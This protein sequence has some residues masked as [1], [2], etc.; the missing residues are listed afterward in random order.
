MS[1]FPYPQIVS[2]R[3]LSSPDKALKGLLDE[4]L[5]NTASD[6]GGMLAVFETNGERNSLLAIRFRGELTDR[7]KEVIESFRVAASSR[8]METME[9]CDSLLAGTRSAYSSCLLAGSRIVG[10][11]HLADS[12][13]GYFDGSLNGGASKLKDQMTAA[14]PRIVL[15]HRMRRTGQRF[16]LLGNSAAFVKFEKALGLAACHESAPVLLSGERGSGKEVAARALHL[17]SAR[18]QGPFIPVVVSGL[19]DE[20]LADELFGHR[21]HSFTGAAGQRQGKFKAAHDGTL[22]LDEIG[23]LPASAQTALLRVIELGEVSP[24]GCDS[25]MHTNAR[26]V[27]ATNKD[28][29]H[30][31]RRGD[32]RSDLFDRLDVVR[33]RVPSLRERKS[34][35]PLMVRVFLREACGEAGRKTALSKRGLCRS[36]RLESPLP[37]LSSK[38]EETL[39][40]YWWPGNVRELKNLLLRMAIQHPEKTLEAKDFAGYSPGAEQEDRPEAESLKLDSVIGRHILIV[41]QRNGH[42]LSRT[43]S[44]LGIPLST[45]RGKMRRLKLKPRR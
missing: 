13:S 42:N 5:R 2:G 44:D 27:A 9:N 35:I 6:R 40:G 11:V 45:L 8:L 28:L 26:I 34:D 12:R 20:L 38:L 4:A 7:G 3:L 1:E 19:K 41:L 43:A 25:P 33:L 36:C 23:D 39:K 17:L 21:Q 10:F 15:A 14:L 24:I 30:L 37:C 32:F 18:W 22:F 31:V 16:H 29:V